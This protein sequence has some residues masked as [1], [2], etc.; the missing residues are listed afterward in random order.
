ML[1]AGVALTAALAAGTVGCGSDDEGTAATGADGADTTSVEADPPAPP[2]KAEYIAAADEICTRFD[3]KQEVFKV[4]SKLTDQIV[5]SQSTEGADEV[6][7][8]VDAVADQRQDL[9]DALRELEPPASGRPSDYFAA[10]EKSI[11][12]T[13]DLAD[14]WD[15]YGKGKADGPTVDAALLAELDALEVNA[16]QG[17]KYGFEVC[18]APIKDKK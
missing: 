14:T 13:R 17:K 8:A 10:R 11:E 5:A 6:A 1:V 18:S 12:V 16:K 9:T 4:R 15:D 7:D 3:K 2:T